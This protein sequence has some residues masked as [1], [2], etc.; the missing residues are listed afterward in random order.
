M[1]HTEKNNLPSSREEKSGFTLL[2]S[3]VLESIKKTILVARKMVNASYTTSC[4][5]QAYQELGLLLMDAI[6]RKEIVWDNPHVCEIVKNIDRY[7]VDLHVFEEQI[8][9]IKSG[10]LHNKL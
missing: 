2:L 5:N 6:K 8:R 9:R 7:N 3:T 1:Q 4:L 10:S